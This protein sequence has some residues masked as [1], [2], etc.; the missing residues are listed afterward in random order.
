MKRRRTQLCV[1][2]VRTRRNI[3]LSAQRPVR[4]CR[5]GV[6]VRMFTVHALT[7]ALHRPRRAILVATDLRTVLDGRLA[8]SLFTN[9]SAC[10]RDYGEWSGRLHF[11]T[12]SRSL[13]D[14]ALVA[15]TVPLQ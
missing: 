5:C 9:R 15:D 4:R 6:S 13:V 11:L 8:F 7:R 2:M 14:L 10:T 12:P 3:A 1:C